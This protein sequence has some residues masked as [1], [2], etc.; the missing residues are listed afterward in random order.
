MLEVIKVLWTASG[1]PFTR[2]PVGGSAACL[3]STLLVR[4]LATMEADN[5]LCFEASTYA[6]LLVLEY[7]WFRVFDQTTEWVT[8][9]D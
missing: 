7:M 8:K 5:T 2:A 3:S 4:R 1:V 9:V 6:Y